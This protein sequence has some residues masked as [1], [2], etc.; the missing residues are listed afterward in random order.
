V[1]C[2]TVYC[3]NYDILII[4]FAFGIKTIREVEDE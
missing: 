2:G 4:T 3:E 1:I